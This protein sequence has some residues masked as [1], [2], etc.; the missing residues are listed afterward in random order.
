MA[1]DFCFTIGTVSRWSP[2]RRRGPVDGG[3]LDCFL[4]HLRPQ[5]SPPRAD[6]GRADG[7][8]AGSI[9]SGCGRGPPNL[10]QPVSHDFK[11]VVGKVKLGGDT[12][13]KS[14]RFVSLCRSVA[15]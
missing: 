14:H 8:P 12:V 10:S 11:A 2:R 5:G 4:P 1:I 9:A 13:A 7:A 3:C 6:I 15:V